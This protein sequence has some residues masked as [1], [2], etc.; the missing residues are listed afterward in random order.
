MPEESAV[1]APDARD[2]ATPSVGFGSAAARFRLV[3][4]AE[5]G[6]WAG[7]L[8]G[9]F[10]KYVIVHNAIGVHVFGAVH[11]AIFVAYLVLSLHARRALGWDNKTTAYALIASI[12]PFG[13]IVFERWADR[14]G[15]LRPARA[16][17]NA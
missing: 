15:R 17:V 5:A 10:F 6:S 11:G 12:P 13:S 4:I 3:A 7:L 1:P 9:M 8:V 14:T 16:L 2:A